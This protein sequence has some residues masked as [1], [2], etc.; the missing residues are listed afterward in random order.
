MI[1]LPF[2]SDRRLAP[3]GGGGR[4][5]TVAIIADR[6]FGANKKLNLIYLLTFGSDSG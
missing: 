3:D 6:I 1:I 5:L 4:S 2:G